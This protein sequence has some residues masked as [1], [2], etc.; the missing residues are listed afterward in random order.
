[1]KNIFKSILFL[2]FA[3]TVVS[4]ED[5]S[6]FEYLTQE[7]E[8]R[9]TS[10]T[11]GSAIELDPEFEN[12]PAVTFTWENANFGSPTEIDYV[13]QAAL[14]GSDFADP[15][16]VGTTNGTFFSMKI[17]EL[18]GVAGDLELDPF[19][20]GAIEFRVKAAIGTNGDLVKYSDVITYL[21][22]PYTTELPKI[23]VPGN[24]QGWNPPVAP[25]LASSGFGQTDYE[26]F[27][28][29]DGE[30][31]FL[32]PQPDGSFAWGA[33]DWGDDGSFS[34]TLVEQNESNC[35][36]AT[37][38]YYRVR[39][40]TTTLT[41]SAEPV[42]WGIVGAATPGSW[43]NSTAL[44]YNASTKKWTGVVAM[45]AGEYKFR[46]N[47]A[48]TI[49]LGGD[50]DADGSMNYDGPNLSNA[51]AGNYLVE[52]DLSNPRKYTYTLTP[53]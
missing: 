24:H 38:G 35:G 50:P 18:N 19:T 21:I 30:Y 37:P 53:Q 33:T 27:V 34:G 52:L 10:P 31:K 6:N 9:F 32:A 2:A 7:G 44:E 25:R 39:A 51:T 8:F 20:Q 49:N 4:C 43:D 45:T 1:M 29:L 22:T 41:Y 47:N 5:E 16:D 48:W 46:A 13:L 42:S 26:G 3:G 23:A 15:T 28:W 14:P 11:S 17:S 12:N 36:P 40:N